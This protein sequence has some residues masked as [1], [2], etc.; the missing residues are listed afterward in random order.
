MQN[1]IEYEDIIQLP[2]G[3]SPKMLQRDFNQNPVERKQSLT[4]KNMGVLDES[5]NPYAQFQDHPDDDHYSQLPEHLEQSVDLN[6]EI[7]LSPP[8]SKDYNTIGRFML[9]AVT[10]WI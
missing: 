1:D 3:T 4:Y 7:I 5:L 6:K 2:T 10:F 8:Y 9:S